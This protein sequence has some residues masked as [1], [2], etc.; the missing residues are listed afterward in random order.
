M[1]RRCPG[2]DSFVTGVLF[3]CENCQPATHAPAEQADTIGVDYELEYG[4]DRVEIHTD[5]IHEGE[6][7]LLVDDLIA[8]GGT[9]RA[10]ADH[11]IANT[12]TDG[13]CFW[14]TGAPGL[15]NMPDHKER[16]SDPTNDHEPIDASAAAIMAQGML[17][18]ARYLEDRD[19]EGASRYRQAALTS[20][21]TLMQT[22][23]L[24]LDPAHEGLLL[25]SIYHRPNGWDHVPAG[26][27]S[28][29]G[30]ACQWGDYHLRELALLVQRE[31]QGEPW[32][33]FFTGIER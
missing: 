30:E 21:R 8:T 19:D 25:H 15:A 13:V 18:L 24:S 29:R 16:P 7:I 26:R 22:P 17:I 3:R 33:T 32:L 28:P 4:T 10:T 5:A 6:R 11:F 27:K 9:A 31:A 23:Y 1:R 12:P 2:R 14:D 20:L